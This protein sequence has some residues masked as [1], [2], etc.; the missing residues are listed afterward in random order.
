MKK[1][2]KDIGRLKNNFRLKNAIK[3]HQMIL[4]FLDY[5]YKYYTTF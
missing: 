2:N 3:Q 4:N 1:D 5:E